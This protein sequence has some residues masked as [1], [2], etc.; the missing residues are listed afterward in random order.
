M[1]FGVFAR[2]RS[3][4]AS[5]ALLA[6]I[7]L[8]LWQVRE[9]GTAKI[10]EGFKAVGWWGFAGV[11]VLSLARFLARSAAWTALIG[12]RVSIWR[13]LAASIGG[14]AA[15]NLTPLSLL[16]SEPTKAIYLAGASGS[17]RALAALA[18]ENFFYSVSVALY[19]VLGTAAML[20]FFPLDQT[21]QRIGVL[22]LAAMGVVL[23]GAGWMGW[24]KPT[25]AS[26]FLARVPGVRL[27]RLA[28]RVRS[29]ESRS[30]GS[31]GHEGARL[32]A[33]FAAETIFHVS[34]FLEI[35]L[36]LW[37]LTGRSLPLEALVLDTFSRIANILFKVVPFQLGVHQVATEAIG[38]AIGMPAGTG[39][40]VSL[41]RTVRVLFWAGVGM[42]LLATRAAVIR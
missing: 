28:E 23:A 17:G 11:L 15:G 38:L 14:D 42:A 4:L 9:I 19:I 37:L 35:W 30:Y 13:A 29:F 40:L 24:Q 7:A 36:T 34:S 33:V 20:E 32:S 1:L 2:R 22:A 3:L 21:V 39:V 16:V 27:A 5:A 25:L 26:A 12:E 6:G 41:V 8:L 18:A 10:A 31:A